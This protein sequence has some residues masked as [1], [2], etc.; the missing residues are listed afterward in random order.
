ML[1]CEYALLKLY[2]QLNL[3]P[4]IYK[5]ST[6][7]L[8][9]LHPQISYY[10]SLAQPRV[11]HTLFYLVF[12]VTRKAHAIIILICPGELSNMLKVIDMMNRNQY[13]NTGV[14]LQSLCS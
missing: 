5:A 3:F 4:T 13:L 14:Q 10:E 11:L 12:S 9:N 1:L 2:P 7:P 6:H 8:Y